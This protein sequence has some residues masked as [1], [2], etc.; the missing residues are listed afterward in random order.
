[1]TRHK[2][3]KIK[4]KSLYQWH[5]YI[6]VSIA[7]FVL[8]LSITGIALNHTTEFNLNTHYIKNTTLL[9]H[10]GIHAPEK[11]YSFNTNDIWV[12][13][14]QDRL[15]LNEIDLGTTTDQLIGVLLYREM[16]IMGFKDGLLLYTPDGELIEKLANVDGLPTA[17]NAIGI[18]DKNE[19]AVKSTNGVYTADMNISIWLHDTQAITVWNDA[20]ELPD[21]LEQ[22]LLEKFRGKGL[23]FERIIL[24]L[25]SGRLFNINGVYF[26]DF[27][28]LLLIFLAC[29]GL[30]IWTTRWLKQ[31]KHHK[32]KK[33]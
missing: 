10:Y 16:I 7:I 8:L 17:I 29:S 30:W 23:S 19:I 27:V 26:M 25:H 1:M 14:W 4:L 32:P 13:Q 5:R 22:V 24:D 9:N 12:S 20:K 2:Q 31:K 3:T 33:L 15:Y 6:G 18:T 11:I 28:A 21:N